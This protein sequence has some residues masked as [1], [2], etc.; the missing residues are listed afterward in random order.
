MTSHKIDAACRDKLKKL[1][2]RLASNHPGE[3]VATVTAIEKALK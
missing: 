2:P 3:V 1:I